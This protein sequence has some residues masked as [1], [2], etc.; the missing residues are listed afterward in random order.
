MPNLKSKIRFNG[1]D[2]MSKVKILSALSFNKTISSNN[3][4]E[5]IENIE[6]KDFDILN[7]LI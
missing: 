4:M 6:S 1:Y 2:A 3:P 7:N 5:G